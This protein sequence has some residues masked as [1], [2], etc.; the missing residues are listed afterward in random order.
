LG[1]QVWAKLGTGELIEPGYNKAVSDALTC[2]ERYIQDDNVWEQSRWIFHKAPN[3]AVELFTENVMD[4][5]VKNVL[6]FLHSLSGY[7]VQMY[8]VKY[9]EAV[10]AKQQHLMIDRSITTSGGSVVGAD[11]VTKENL[12][13][14]GSDEG[15]GEEEKSETASFVGLKLGERAWNN[16]Q[17]AI[18]C[19]DSIHIAG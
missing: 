14:S 6:K 12:G 1:F 16:T 13:F 3:R 11:N 10:V 18:E 4:L 15:Q 17:L 9:M 5:G 2:I 19:M 8:A 7:K